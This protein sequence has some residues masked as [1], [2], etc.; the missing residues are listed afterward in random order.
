MSDVGIALLVF[1]LI[2][3][4]IVV[5]AVLIRLFGVYRLT[6]CFATSEERAVLTKN[7]QYN[8]Y[9]VNKNCK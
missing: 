3:V 8:G 9:M 5:I 7:E 4:A 1:A 6:S 2:V